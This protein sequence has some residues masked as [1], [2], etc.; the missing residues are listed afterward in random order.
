M[1]DQLRKSALARRRAIKKG[2]LP[3]SSATDRHRARV[4][5]SLRGSK[6]PKAAPKAHGC[7]VNPRTGRAILV[8]GSTYKQLKKDKV[9]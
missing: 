1:I 9:I 2:A 7:I 8:G 5:K 4:A 6:A 3:G